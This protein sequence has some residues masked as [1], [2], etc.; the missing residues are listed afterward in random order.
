[1]ILTLKV[2]SF[3]Y[4]LKVWPTGAG[5]T[6]Q[7]LRCSLFLQRTWVCFLAHTLP[8][9]GD[10]LPSSGP[11]RHCS[12]ATNTPLKSKIFKYGSGE[13]G[14]QVRAQGALTKDS[15]LIP[16]PTW[17]LTTTCNSR[18]SSP[19]LWGHCRHNVHS[20][21][22]HRH[23]ADVVYFQQLKLSHVAVPQT[24]PPA[25]HSTLCLPHN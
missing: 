8:D 10:S 9:L 4:R 7:W 15:C 20:V 23:K 11:C 1:M 2:L 18:A 13:M 24:L 25:A 14:Q 17:W 16:V 5:E 6:A 21:H 19:G 22:R 3:E 12:H